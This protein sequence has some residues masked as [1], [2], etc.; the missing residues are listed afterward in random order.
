M[1]PFHSPLKTPSLVNP[2]T[3]PNYEHP[4]ITYHVY[5]PNSNYKKSK[6]GP[7]D[8]YISVIQARETL[9]PAEPELEHLMRQTPFHP[10][11]DS[12]SNVYQKCKGGIRNIIL[13]IV[14]QGVIS[15]LNISDAAFGLNALWQREKKPNSRPKGGTGP[16]GGF[17]GKNR[18]RR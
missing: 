14:D 12:N 16:R 3:S 10:W 7:P 5:K 1:V 13:A 17:K 15:F 8:F 2:W 4:N 9:L 6:P 18:G 11:P